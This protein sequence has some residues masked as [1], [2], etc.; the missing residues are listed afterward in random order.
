[1]QIRIYYTSDLKRALDTVKM[2]YKGEI[3]ET[4]LTGEITLYI[5]DKIKNIIGDKP[6]SIDKVG[7]SNSQVLYFD[8]M[9][10]KIENQS[11][12]SDNEHRMMT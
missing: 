5:P 9:V 8:D 4:K 1:M 10:L 12:E 7:M 3:I 2:V 6:Y 11:E